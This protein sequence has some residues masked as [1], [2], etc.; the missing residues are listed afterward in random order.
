MQWT[1]LDFVDVNGT[2]RIKEW[3]TNLPPSSQAAVKAKLTARIQHL[4]GLPHL[5]G[6]ITPLVGCDGVMEIRMVTHNVQ[7]RPLVCYG[8]NQREVVLLVVVEER[9]G[10]L[11]RSACDIAQRRR[12]LVFADNEGKRVCRHDF[13]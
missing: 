8:P 5:G 2:N 13:S 3:L 4:Q 6:Y 12:A 1:F 7:Y 9:N 11:P 10:R